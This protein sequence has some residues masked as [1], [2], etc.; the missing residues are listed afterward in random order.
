MTFNGTTGA[1]TDANWSNA[2]LVWVDLADQDGTV[3]SI[4]LA[5][6]TTTTLTI[7]VK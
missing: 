6:G 7:T 1:T 5:D 2:T 3:A 4:K